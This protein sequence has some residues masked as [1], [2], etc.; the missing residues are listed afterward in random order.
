M[1][2]KKKAGH[3]VF[4]YTVVFFLLAMPWLAPVALSQ[5]S[6]L[7]KA[8]NS[9]VQLK[10][11]KRFFSSGD[12]ISASLKFSTAQPV[13]NA[14]VVFVS[15]KTGDAEGLKLKQLSA[16]EYSTEG[17]LK[18]LIGLNKEK[19]D[20]IL[21]VQP[22]EVLTAYYY[23]TSQKN[24]N[25]QAKNNPNM[26][27][28][29][30]QFAFVR[31]QKNYREGLMVSKNY[32]LNQNETSNNAA[33][34]LVEGQVPV[35]VAKNQVIFYAEDDQ[36][37]KEFLQYS[38]CK[39]IG[40]ASTAGAKLTTNIKAVANPQQKGNTAYLIEV[41]VK[42]QNLNDFGQLRQFLGLKQKVFSSDE[43][44]LKL[45]QFC[46]MANLDGYA[47]SLN[48]RMQYYSGSNESPVQASYFANPPGTGETI[49]VSFTDRFTNIPKVW[50]YM[51]IWDRDATRI[52]VGIIDYGFHPTIDY[53]NGTSMVQ[54]AASPIGTRCAPGA[55]LGAPTV[56]ASLFGRRVWHGNAVQG[57][58]GG[59]LNNNF[60]TAGT[61]GQVAIPL[62]VKM[63]GADAYAFNIGG[64][65]RTAV[66]N[67]A[68]VINI[69]GGFPCKVLTSLGDFNYCDPGSRGAVC[70]A[71]FP[72]VQGGAIIACSA[73]AWIPFATETCIAITSSVYISACVAQFALGNPG[74]II[75]SGVQYAKERGVPVVV[76]A[77]NFIGPE[78]I[79]VPELRPFI[80]LDERRMTV[81][82]WG[83]VPAGL[84]DVICVGAANPTAPYANNQVFGNRVDV[85]APE[86][87]DYM[88]P[89]NGDLPAGPSNPTVL[90]RDFN[91]TSSAAPFIT[92]LI[93]DAIALNPQFNRSTS[94]NVGAIVPTLRSL[95]TST[96]WN[97]A[98]LPAD[99]T[100][101]RRNLVNPIAFL[102][103]VSFAAG[104]PVPSLSAAVY[105]NDWNME[106]TES[107]DDVTPTV[108]MHSAGGASRTGS[109]IHIPGSDGAANI[110]DI[111][112]YRINVLST[113]RPA[114]GERI[115]V[116]LRTPTG[117]RFGNLTVRGTGLT[118]LRTDVISGSE[119]EKVFQGPFVTAG[120]MAL[121]FSVEGATPDQDNIYLLTIGNAV[122]P[123][124]SDRDETITLA[125]IT[126][127]LCPTTL[128]RGDREFGG[129]PLINASI[130][131]ERTA[132]ENGI[133]AVITYRAEE[134][135]GDRSTATGTFRQR[136][137]NAATGLRITAIDATS[138]SSQVLNFRGAGAGAEFGICNEGVVQ[139]ATVT[140]GLVR[141]IVVVGDTGGNDISAGG[142]CRCDTKIKSI[143]FN[144]VRI[145][146][147][148]R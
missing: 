90:K 93:A 113:Y 133:D 94:S 108:I 34:I 102:Q 118:L 89:D 131:L 103:A 122:A 10:L 51:A 6:V 112:R 124:A 126:G 132:D 110:T 88:A 41:P 4:S 136:V 98:A 140:G 24:K 67:G 1:K 62:A 65:I 55:A 80:N 82:D 141:K 37:W 79:S 60:G 129:G 75:S 45:V 3:L 73:L 100:G 95:L 35:Q 56:G 78:S 39:L 81:E 7:T 139:D 31:G 111:D 12:V 137:F 92:G 44:A 71:L 77:G 120:G 32:A 105:G 57:R 83:I 138:S 22:D 66:D 9:P 18:I 33:T 70:A 115:L 125:D 13:P 59:V 61:G 11:N 26:P 76:S 146:V 14:Y 134:T 123:T 145:R 74:E 48:P 47:V 116:K 25:P 107:T 5:G 42:D 84:P 27:D 144:Q 127:E 86:D 50:N 121:D 64:A 53:R 135:G 19:N 101:R 69:S 40:Q 143:N 21:T 8:N 15:P 2:S 85:W 96:A 72:I 97:N 52:R 16:L 104:S 106:A 38:N 20:G 148:T 28:M 87:G 46:A 142:G 99:P 43:D 29:I 130:R 91:G 54:C 49:P 128:E 30:C 36:Q 17:E 68:D 147:A 117:S 58:S 109:I 63:S 114:G 119:E 23:N